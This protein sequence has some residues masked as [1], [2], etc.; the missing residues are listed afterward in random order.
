[1]SIDAFSKNFDV[2]QTA[3]S[4]KLD[5]FFNVLKYKS[6]KRKPSE[7]GCVKYNCI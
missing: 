5:N 4:F 2:L 3:T 6:N 1:M 7:A